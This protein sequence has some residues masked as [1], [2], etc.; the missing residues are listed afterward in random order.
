MEGSADPWGRTLNTLSTTRYSF[1]SDDEIL[2]APSLRL[3]LG[4]ARGF[5]ESRAGS[6]RLQGREATLPAQLLDR[7]VIRTFPPSAAKAV[8]LGRRDRRA[9]ALRRPKAEEQVPFDYAEGRLFR[10]LCE[11]VGVELFVERNEQHHVGSVASYPF[12]YT[13]GRLLQKTQGWGTL[14]PE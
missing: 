14:C 13:Q 4:Y 6:W 5:G 9:E 1:F 11:R 7:S 3:P 8:R 10:V 2:G 12:D